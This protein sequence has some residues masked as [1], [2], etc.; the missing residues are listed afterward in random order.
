MRIKSIFYRPDFFRRQEFTTGQALSFYSLS[1]LFLVL[2][3]SL[4]L[5]PAVWRVN[6]FFESAKWQEQK[7]IIKNLYPDNL[8]LTFNDGKL[9]TNQSEPIA[10]PFPKEWSDKGEYPA[11]L[12]VID[13]E[14][15]VSRKAIERSNTLI[16][17]SETEIGF[18]DTNKGKTEIIALA[19][20]NINKKIEVTNSN[21]D[22][23]II[24]RGSS[25]VKTAT[26]F[27][28]SVLPLLMYLGLWIGYIVY[29][30][31]GAFVV[32][33]AA[34][35]RDHKLDYAQAYRS[36]LYFLPASFVVSLLMSVMGF[37]IPLLF[38]LVLFGIAL[39]NFEKQE[40]KIATT[41]PVSAVPITPARPDESK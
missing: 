6:R 13:R 5:I 23:W 26:N 36:T 39:L 35:I 7:T 37:H 32:W 30:L 33:L 41:L 9:T 15:E 40:K 3:F 1:I 11:N 19:K 8:V 27:L 20:M 14:A 24:E 22:Y 28:M 17:A 12:L 25:I 2:G 34:H 31:F 4:L 29:S 16:L 21:F 18:S 38:T 10:I